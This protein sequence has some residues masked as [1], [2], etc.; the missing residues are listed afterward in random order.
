MDDL[1]AVSSHAERSAPSI[2]DDML[3]PHGHIDGVSLGSFFPAC[4]F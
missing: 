3:A 2:D 4:T 1:K